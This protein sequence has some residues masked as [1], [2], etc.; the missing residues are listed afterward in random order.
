MDDFNAKVGEGGGKNVVGPL[1]MG[2]RNIRGQKLVECC[3]T[4]N[5]IVGNMWF[6]QPKRRKWTWKSAGDGSRNQIDYVLISKRFS[7]ALLSAK[8]YH[9]PDC[10]S[11]HVPVA[12]KFKLKL[13]KTRIKAKYVKLDLALLKSYFNNTVALS[14]FFFNAFN[15]K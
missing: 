8:T 9:G 7:H 11:D 2:I 10:Y 13:K 1:G 6:Q 3:H 14:Q 15:I 12:A 4:N 5:L